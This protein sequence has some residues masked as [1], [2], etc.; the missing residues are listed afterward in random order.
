MQPRRHKDAGERHGEDRASAR[1]A[2]R[3]GRSRVISPCVLRASVAP[4]LHLTVTSGRLCARVGDALHFAR[5]ASI[6]PD[7]D[8]F[9]A[10]LGGRSGG[11]AEYQDRR[12]GSARADGHGSDCQR[13]SRRCLARLSVLRRDRGPQGARLGGRGVLH[14]G[15]GEPLHDPGSGDRGR[16]RLGASIQDAHPRAKAGERER[17]QRHRRRRVEQRHRRPRSRHRLVPELRPLHPIRIRLGRG[18]AAARRRRGV[19]GVEREAIRDARRDARRRG[20]ER[21][22]LVRRLR[23]G[24]AGDS[25]AGPRQRAR[26]PQ[27]GADLRHRPLAVGRPAR[28]L[29]Q[30][31]SSDRLGVRRRRR[32]WRWRTHQDRPDDS[33]LQA[34]RRNRRAR[35]A[36]GKPAARHQQIPQ[37]GS[38]RQLARRRAVQGVV[39]EAG[40]KRRQSKRAAAACCGP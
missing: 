15:D 7:S 35:P 4:R 8:W 37:L 33:G 2:S 12:G 32:A 39:L 5:Y 40:G 20:A 11:V 25:H 31:R 13:G 30:R 14:R 18:D 23:A 17:V 6:S 10:H 34:A 27:A 19:E 9:R 36:G 24:G 3:G 16:A 28:Q 22:S 1:P 29:R 21:R 38:G 26:R